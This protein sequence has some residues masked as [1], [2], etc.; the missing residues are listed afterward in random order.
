M[1][2]F[3]NVLS[4]LLV[5]PLA[6]CASKNSKT[7]YPIE[8]TKDLVSSTDHAAGYCLVGDSRT[9]AIYWALTGSMSDNTVAKIANDSVVF[10][11]SV[12]E[13]YSYL[14]DTVLP[15]IDPYVGEGTKV[16]VLTGVNDIGQISTDSY[17][18]LLEDTASAYASRGASLYYVY[19]NP[20]SDDLAPSGTT[21]TNDKVNEWNRE[22]RQGL[23]E[24]VPCID[25]NAKIT[26]HIE[27]ADFLHYENSTNLTIYEELMEELDSKDQ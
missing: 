23:S 24:D 1:I 5:L 22:M 18:S 20:V 27:W 8:E 10:A 15:L 16:A 14:K 2:R 25:I 11:A 26:G 21:L 12:G 19:V 13:G 9:V 4:L 7:W 17:I 6:G 3:R